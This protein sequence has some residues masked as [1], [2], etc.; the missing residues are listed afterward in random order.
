MH[1][2]FSQETPVG[3]IA[4]TSAAAMP[5]INGSQV[6]SNWVQ[7]FCI[8]ARFS[9]PTIRALD[10]GE[11]TKSSRVEVVAAIAHQI[12]QET[13]YPK[14]K[15]YDLICEKLI[16][17]YPNVKDSIGSGYVSAFKIDDVH[18][19]TG[20]LL[21]TQGSWKAQ[22]RQK[23]KNLRRDSGIKED[24]DENDSQAEQPQAKKRRTEQSVN[25]EDF[26]V[27]DISEC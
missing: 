22:I 26:E 16:A 23:M 17:K 18:V 19:H 9:K 20:I 13:W 5:S 1:K 10:S 2:Q 15:E 25:L 3:T 11:L 8:P 4:S 24:G 6:S 21:H 12:I 27:H 7:S 14:S